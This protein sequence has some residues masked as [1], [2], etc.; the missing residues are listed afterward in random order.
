[1]SWNTLPPEI[2][3]LAQTVLTQAQLAA[4]QLELDGHSQWHIAHQLNISRWAVRDRLH[5]STVTLH[6]H[7]V[8]QDASGN[9]YLEET[10]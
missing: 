5:S 7:G 4:W 9:W 8:R 2:A 6:R 1:M 10:A 3:R